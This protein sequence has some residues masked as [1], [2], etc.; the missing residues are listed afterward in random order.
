MFGHL[1]VNY[2]DAKHRIGSAGEGLGFSGAP[3]GIRCRKEER[4]PSWRLLTRFL[5]FH[6][7]KPY[8]VIILGDG[9]SPCD[10]L[11][12]KWETRSLSNYG[13]SGNCFTSFGICLLFTCVQIDV[14]SHVIGHAYETTFIHKFSSFLYVPGMCSVQ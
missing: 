13:V 3:G 6:S 9:P 4:P 12:A 10:C 2:A 7:L 14:F 5:V 8:Q 1:D 11:P